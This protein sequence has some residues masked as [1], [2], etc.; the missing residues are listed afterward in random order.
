MMII[1]REKTICVL[2]FYP[3]V[4]IWEHIYF[5]YSILKN[6]SG[7][8]DMNLRA[9]GGIIKFKILLKIQICQ[10]PYDKIEYRYL[11]RFLH[12]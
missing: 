12:S 1:H 3:M 6:I 8:P 10:L 11:Q 2:N 9:N 5:E 7:H 4:A